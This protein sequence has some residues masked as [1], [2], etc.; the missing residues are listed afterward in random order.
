MVTDI[1]KHP[2]SCKHRKKQIL[3]IEEKNN[4]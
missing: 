3:D 2:V 1:M 4:V